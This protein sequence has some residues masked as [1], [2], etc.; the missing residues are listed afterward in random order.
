MSRSITSILLFLLVMAMTFPAMAGG[1]I[2]ITPFIGYQ[3]G[4][5]LM[6]KFKYNRLKEL[7]L[8]IQDQGMEDQ[9]TILDQT[10]E[11]W[12]G[13]LEQLDDILVIGRR[14]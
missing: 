13:E 10:I 7:I 2:E 12:K 11:R 8:K 5:E 3:F 4:G 6:K 1:D 9:R 14:F